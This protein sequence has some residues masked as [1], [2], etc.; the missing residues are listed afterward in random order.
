MY[1]ETITYVDY[2]GNEWTED[3]RFNM[4]KA[5]LYKLN[6]KHG[7]DFEKF[8]NSLIEKK[9]YDGM[10]SLF[11]EILFMSYGIKSED[12]KR[13]MKSKEISESFTQ[14]EAYSEFISKMMNDE[15]YLINFINQVIPHQA[16]S[17]VMPA[18]NK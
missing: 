14:T 5:D 1:K 8:L 16:A 12:G 17:E 9:D 3:F 2:D 13:F 7:G 15:N 11:E 4:S 18:N 6:F 10:Y